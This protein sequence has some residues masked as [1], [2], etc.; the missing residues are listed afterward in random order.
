V[1]GRESTVDVGAPT[2]D[3]VVEALV[4]RWSMRLALVAVVVSF[5]LPP[6]GLG[7]DLCV[8]HRNTGLPCPGCGLTRS[9]THVAHLDVVG[10]FV[11]HPFGPAIWL[12]AVA[13]GIG[14]L[15]GERRRTLLRT[16]LERRGRRLKT[17]YLTFVYGFVA[18]G[19][20]RLLVAIVARASG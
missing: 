20:A 13:L 15:I 3:W 9:L 6:D 8:F 5:L 7:V 14:A 2:G 16:W 19:I 12:L 18:F 4:H 11:L 10:A 1:E 17:A